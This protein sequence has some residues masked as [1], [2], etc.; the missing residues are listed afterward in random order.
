[1]A[2]YDPPTLFE[3]RIIFMSLFHGVD[4]TK[5]FGKNVLRIPKRSRN[6]Q[7]NLSVGIGLLSVQET[8]IHGMERTSTNMTDSGI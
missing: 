7:R 2:I 5:K 3:D 8:K 6:T 4:W 1:M